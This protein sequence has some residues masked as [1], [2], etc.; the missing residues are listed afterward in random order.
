MHT[1]PWRASVTAALLQL[2]GPLLLLGT[3]GNR[4]QGL[5]QNSAEAYFVFKLQYFLSE[6][7]GF[8]D[9]ECVS[10]VVGLAVGEN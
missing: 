6:I 1:E 9:D 5:G 7:S 10:V 3:A 2:A 8:H 4:K